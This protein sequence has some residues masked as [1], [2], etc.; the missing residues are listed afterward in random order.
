MDERRGG[1]ATAE[2]GKRGR[3]WG[4]IALLAGGV[5]AG[6]VLWRRRR[7][8][9][10][11]PRWYALVYR[12][13][14]LL[15][16]RVWDRARPLRDLVELIEGESAPA[17]GRA[18]DLGC[19]TGTDSVYL[20]RRGWEVIGVDMVPRALAIARRRAAAAGVS[21]RFLRG[22]VTRLPELGVGPG[23]TLLLDF[24]CFHTLPPDRREAYVR[25]VSAV[26]APGATF[27]L[28]GFVRAPRLAP[29]H[30]GVS[31]E[32]VRRRFG[33]G[34]E[35]L[36]AAPTSVDGVQVAGWPADRLFELWR[37]RLRRLPASGDARRRSGAPA[38]G[39]GSAG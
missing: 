18:L 9:P 30:A 20:A 8:D 28:F 27:L 19:G 14:Y 23:H 13:V 5:V 39:A 10:G 38:A 6:V 35:L 36:E 32:E 12:A 15:G 26:A 16:L 7:E 34:W 37:F 21:P 25:S 2:A 1:A 3:R 33:G 4:A 17:P 31:P 11:R 24:G 22:D 29:M